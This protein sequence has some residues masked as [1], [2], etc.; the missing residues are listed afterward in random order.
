M[1]VN[2]QSMSVCVWERQRPRCLGDNSSR[3]CV[4][5]VLWLVKCSYCTFATFFSISKRLQYLLHECVKTFSWYSRGFHYQIFIAL[6][7]FR[8]FPRGTR[9]LQPKVL[10]DASWWKWSPPRLSE[11]R[12]PASSR[13]SLMS[14]IRILFIARQDALRRCLCITCPYFR[15]GVSGCFESLWCAETDGNK[16]KTWEWRFEQVVV[17]RQN[18]LLG[19]LC[20]DLKGRLCWADPHV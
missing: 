11:W 18:P 3:D 7:G 9:T 14:L 17:K 15:A 10:L 8:T 16:A 13:T 1:R 2:Q 12:S 19:L 6:F 4:R 5:R 20:L